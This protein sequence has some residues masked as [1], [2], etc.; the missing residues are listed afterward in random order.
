MDRNGYNPSILGD[1]AFCAICGKN[2]P[3]QRHEVF[4]GANRPKS[5]KYGLWISIC[6]SCHSIIHNSDGALDRRL[7][8]QAQ[9]QA[10]TVYG[11]STAE[12]RLIFGKNYRE[13]E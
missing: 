11:W 4:H 8:R 6:P 12:F 5:K 3:L 10:Q 9:E 7:K 13:D 2:G 1:Y